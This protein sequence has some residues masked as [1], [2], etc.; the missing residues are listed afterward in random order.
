M[1]TVIEGNSLNVDLVLNRIPGITFTV[2]VNATNLDTAGKCVFI[3]LNLY[4]KYNA[5]DDYT[6]S[7]H[8]VY[9]ASNDEM[10]SI[11]I[12]PRVDGLLELNETF[13]L[14]FEIEPDAREVGVTYNSSSVATITIQNID[15]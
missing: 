12:S 7:S 15:S 1:A 3:C 11:I 9:F 14:Q 5:G 13:Q 4:W 2:S 8:S 6:I 10:K